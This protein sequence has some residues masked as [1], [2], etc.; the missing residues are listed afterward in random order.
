MFERMN[1]VGGWLSI[2]SHVGE[3]TRDSRWHPTENGP[4]PRLAR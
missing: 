1:G 3:G 2:E 4:V